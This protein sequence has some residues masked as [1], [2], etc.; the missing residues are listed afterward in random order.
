MALELGWWAGSLTAYQ[1]GLSYSDCCRKAG[2]AG[3]FE[4]N[5]RQACSAACCSASKLSDTF[6]TDDVH[7]VSVTCEGGSWRMRWIVLSPQRRLIP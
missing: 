1:A 5:E 2:I 6:D 7:M 4:H 3:P